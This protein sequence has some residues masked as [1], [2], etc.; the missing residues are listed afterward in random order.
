ML[1]GGERH[2][3]IQG[4]GRCDCDER[5]GV[6]MERWLGYRLLTHIGTLLKE[7]ID[8]HYLLTQAHSVSNGSKGELDRSANSRPI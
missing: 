1:L 8:F 6:T 5:V 3:I 2:R 7:R 4:A